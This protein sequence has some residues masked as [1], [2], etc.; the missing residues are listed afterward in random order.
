MGADRVNN[1]GGTVAGL[2]LSTMTPVR[3]GNNFAP[4]FGFSYAFNEKT[5]VRGGYGIFFARTTAIMLGT[6]HS[7]NGLQVTGVTLNCVTGLPAPC[8]T[9]P[10]IFPPPPASSAFP[11]I[12]LFSRASPPP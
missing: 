3:D 8:L 7:Q 12:S 2:G 6:A 5:V 1:R 10:P 4:R 9:Y 11:S